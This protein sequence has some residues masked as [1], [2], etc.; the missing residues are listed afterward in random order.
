MIRRPPRS[1]LFPY[2]TLFRSHAVI[3]IDVSKAELSQWLSPSRI[4][5]LLTGIY[6]R[7]AGITGTQIQNDGGTE[8]VYPSTTIVSTRGTALRNAFFSNRCCDRYTLFCVTKKQ[9]VRLAQAMIDSDLIAIGIVERR[10]ILNE[11]S[12]RN[13]SNV[14]CCSVLLEELLHGSENQA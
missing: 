2:T 6:A 10:T 5:V 7:S 4:V 1:T 14:R 8:R 13:P 11:I 9:V 12:S 3:L